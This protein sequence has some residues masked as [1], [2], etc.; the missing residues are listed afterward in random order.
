MRIYGAS[1]AFIKY[2]L[3]DYV[4]Y[5][6]T[7]ILT[8]RFAVSG[9]QAHRCNVTARK[10]CGGNWQ[11]IIEKLDYIQDMGFTAIWISPVFSTE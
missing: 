8:D 4:E 2:I 5:S 6:L 11:G 3:V 1:R 9:G 7:K 10:Y